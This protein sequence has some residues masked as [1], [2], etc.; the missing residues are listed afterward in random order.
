MRLFYSYASLKESSVTRCVNFDSVNLVLV[1]D[2]AHLTFQFA[3]RPSLAQR[4][5]MKQPHEREIAL[6]ELSKREC[7][8]RQTEHCSCRCPRHQSKCDALSTQIT[9][10][11]LCSTCSR[12]FAMMA[13]IK[14]IYS[15][16]ERRIGELENK[17]P[18]NRNTC[19]PKYRK[20]AK[21]RGDLH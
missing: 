2:K 6:R 21:P 1:L 13:K 11:N 8:T 5:T 18:E 14:D 12:I 17:L 19:S 15:R 10:A 4:N 9:S 20:L 7:I 16:M 3:S